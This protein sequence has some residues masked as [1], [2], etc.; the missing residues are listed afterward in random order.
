M[1]RDYNIDLLKIFAILAVVMTHVN[2]QMLEFQ[3]NS[4]T[5]TYGIILGSLS[6]F[7]VPVFLMCSGALMLNNKEIPIKKLYLKYILRFIFALIF[8]DIIY[9]LLYAYYQNINI[10]ESL[11]D[12]IY[13]KSKFHLYYL[14]IIILCY[15]FLP[16]LKK[17]VNGMDK[18]S[19][20]YLLGL[21]FVTSILWPYMRWFEPFSLNNSLMVKYTFSLPYLGI[22]YM[23]FGKYL[24]ENKDD[25]KKLSLIITMFITIIFIIVSTKIRSRETMDLIYWENIN[26]FIFLYSASLF[27]LVNKIKIKE[28]H[29]KLIE[30]LSKG[31]FFVYLSHLIILDHLKFLGLSPI[32]LQGV[33][34]FIYPILLTL[35]IL[36]LTYILY[37]FLRKIRFLNKWIM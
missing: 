37:A 27:T 6:R 9:K 15:A 29:F 1:K 26:P 22:A 28:K 8:W 13:G 20:R 35:F 10:G 33:S 19:Y 7:C 21:I 11:K 17:L 31:S 2:F 4:K 3:L 32:N 30:F 18:L 14:Y 24:Y 16:I 23:L 12:I 34:K 36:L 25:Y 5:F